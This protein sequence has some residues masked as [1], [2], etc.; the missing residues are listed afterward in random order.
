MPEGDEKSKPQHVETKEAVIREDGV[1][2]EVHFK[3]TPTV[4]GGVEFFVRARPPAGVR[5]VSL[6]DNERRK[7]INVVDRKLHVLLIA[8][9]PM[10]EYRF[11]HTMLS[12]HSSIDVDVWLQTVNPATVGQVSQESRRLLV[13]FPR[14]PAELFDYDVV[15]AFDPDWS[16]IPQ[17]SRSLLIKWVGDHSGG[18]ILVA[19]DIY[20]SQL[21]NANDEMAAVQVLYP[22]RLSASISDLSLDARADQPWPVAL[23]KDGAAA[24]FLQL[25]E[26]ESTPGGIWKQFPGVYRCYP[27]GEPK[28]GAT[29]YAHFGDPLRKM[30]T[31]SQFFLRPNSTDRAGRC[32]W[33]ARSCGGWR[34]R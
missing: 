15:V 3:Q 32:I 26:N 19:G 10:R 6:D 13:E 31:V 27:T 4:A 34:R 5:E 14:T 30:S 20:T 1:P 33:A 24:G 11:L 25:A 23:T 29:V 16:R 21:A 22:V 28:A 12:R 9:G 2:V 8:S 18:L 17:E 7:S